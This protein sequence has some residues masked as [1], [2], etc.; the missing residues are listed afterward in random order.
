MRQ[1]QPTIPHFTGVTFTKQFQ[2][3]TRCFYGLMNDAC[4]KTI[5]GTAIEERSLRRI[6][7]RLD[8]RKYQTK[9]VQL[10]NNRCCYLLAPER[11]TQI[12]AELGKLKEDLLAWISKI[13][14][15]RTRALQNKTLPKKPGPKFHQFCDNKVRTFEK[16]CEILREKLP[17]SRL[18]QIKYWRSNWQR[19]EQPSRVFSL[20]IALLRPGATSSAPAR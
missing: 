1:L 4:I 12:K 10:K 3:T 2:L 18:K 14:F 7:Y 13:Y 17:L 5:L 16:A 9:V 6:D 11:D 19:S 15:S 20:E 8:A